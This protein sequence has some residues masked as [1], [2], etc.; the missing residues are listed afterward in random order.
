MLEQILELK[1]RREARLRQKLAAGN[2]RYERLRHTLSSLADERKI[3]QESWARL[4]QNGCG[5]LARDRLHALKRELEEFFQRDKT[6]EEEI[7]SLEGECARWRHER[8]D[9]Q[10]QIQQMRI[11]QEKLEWVLNEGR[12]AYS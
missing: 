2:Q 3:L 9:L 12:D 6:L 10:Q 11:D 5:R 1:K 7:A 8:V 4:G